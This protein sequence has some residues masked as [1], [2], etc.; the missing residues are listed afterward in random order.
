VAFEPRLLRLATLPSRWRLAVI[1]V[2]LSA[3]SGVSCAANA[4][5][6]VPTDTPEL[7]TPEPPAR[8]V[9][10]APVQPTLL[11]LP[12]IEE[13]PPTGVL[14]PT[15]RLG[16]PPPASTTPPPVPPTDPPA[17]TTGPPT[18]R[19]VLRTTA[20]TAEF[21]KRVRAQL[22]RAQIDLGLVKRSALGSDA[23]AQFDSA[24]GFVRQAEEALKVKNLVYA[25]QLADKAATMA[26]LL[27]R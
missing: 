24:M 10:P 21:E 3:V 7:R 17:A 15:R 5:P 6:R 16:T 25:G 11:A 2:A 9:V 14:P 19:P 22:A 26:A 27:R 23:R 1:G 20:N 4:A 18:T 8:V 12:S 13:P